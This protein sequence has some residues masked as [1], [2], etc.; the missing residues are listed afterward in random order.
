MM[1]ERHEIMPSGRKEDRDWWFATKLAV[2]IVVALVA[3][4]VVHVTLLSQP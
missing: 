2:V 1:F 4:Y 3:A